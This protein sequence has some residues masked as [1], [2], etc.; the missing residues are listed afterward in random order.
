MRG[1]APWPRN[2]AT[3]SSPMPPKG[4]SEPFVPADNRPVNITP[5]IGSV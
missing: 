3:A 2:R 4:D 5:F 1:Y